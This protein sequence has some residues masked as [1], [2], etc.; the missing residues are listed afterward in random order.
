MAG[1]FTNK[2]D[3]RTA[4]WDRLQAERLARFPFPPHGRIPNFAGAREAALRLFG[5]SPWKDATRL[6]INPDAAQRSVREEA[7]R[8]G[9]QV[10]M[11]TPR[12]RAGFMLLDPAVIPPEKIRQ[13]A[14]LKTGS[15]WAKKVPLS[16]LPRMDAIVCGSVAVTPDGRRCGKGEG[17]S[18]LEYAILRE[19]GHPAVPV[20]T[21]V[22]RVQIVKEF[23]HDA[24]DL[25]LSVI[26][27]PEEVIRVKRPPPAPPGIDWSRLSE[28]DLDEMPVLRELR[29]LRIAGHRPR[30]RRSKN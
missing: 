15:R 24:N 28:K 18:D 3:A 4:V 11:P 26:A 6:K 8:R 30:R 19:L 25:P 13:A 17:Y 10:F 23:P 22:H 16:R 20:A 14:G 21:T 9:I 7:L 12:L 1:H 27:T 29:A 5:L 2:D